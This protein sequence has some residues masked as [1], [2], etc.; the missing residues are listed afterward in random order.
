MDTE[1]V[2]A[3]AVPIIIGLIVGVLVIKEKKEDKKK[4]K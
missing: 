3:C 4:I 2:L 1:I